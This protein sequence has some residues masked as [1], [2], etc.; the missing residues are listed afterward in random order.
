[1]VEMQV[2]KMLI[3]SCYFLCS[4]QVKINFKKSVFVYF[5]CVCTKSIITGSLCCLNTSQRAY[6][7]R[8]SA[9]VFK[10]TSFASKWNIHW[11]DETHDAVMAEVMKFTCILLL[12]VHLQRCKLLLNI[13]MKTVRKGCDVLASASNEGQGRPCLNPQHHNFNLV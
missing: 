7:E 2:N 13:L 12:I 4:N 9:H 11:L 6:F 8:L 5:P 1:M 3:N 10:P